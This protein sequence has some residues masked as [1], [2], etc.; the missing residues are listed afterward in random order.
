MTTSRFPTLSLLRTIWILMILM[1]PGVVHA[2]PPFGT[3][4]RNHGTVTF[5]DKSGTPFT[6]PSNEVRT[7]VNP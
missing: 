5:K 4:I 1:L 6:K 3:I 7:P 2:Q